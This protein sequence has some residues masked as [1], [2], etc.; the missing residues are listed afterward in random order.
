[1]PKMLGKKAYYRIC[2]CRDCGNINNIVGFRR[3]EKRREKRLWR[4]YEM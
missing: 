1:M 2:V 4:R 3:R